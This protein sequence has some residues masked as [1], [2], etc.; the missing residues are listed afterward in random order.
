[1]IYADAGCSL[2]KSH[3]WGEYFNYLK[4]YNAVF[5]Q[6]RNIYYGWD[7]MYKENSPKIK[8]WIKQSTIDYFNN[9]FKDKNWLEYNKIMGGVVFI[10]KNEETTIINEWLKI[11]LFRPDLLIDPFGAEAIHPQNDISAHR[12]DQAILTPLVYFLREIEK[13]IV[14]PENTDWKSEGAIIGSRK[15]DTK[16]NILTTLKYVFKSILRKPYRFFKK[17][18][19]MIWI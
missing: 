18:N 10:K 5:F 9:Y 11:V 7:K 13:L 15:K 12:H 2:S 19:L 6:Y 14:L 1:V 16:H 3:E 4:H 8:H 17:S